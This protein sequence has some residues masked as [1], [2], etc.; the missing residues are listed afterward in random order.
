MMGI[1][2]WLKRFQREVI[3]AVVAGTVALGSTW[4]AL[5]LLEWLAIDTL[6][7]LRPSEAPDSRLLLV[8]VEESDIQ[9]LG[10]WPLSDAIL[11]EVLETLAAETPRVIGLDLYRDLPQEPG[12]DRLQTLMRELPNLVGIEKGLGGGLV[13]PPPILAERNLVGLADVPQDRDGTIRR[14]IV[15]APV[16]EKIKLG[17]STQV[18]LLYL[19]QLGITLEVRD[20]AQHQYQLGQAQFSPLTGRE[21]G[22]SG[23][24]FGGY[25][26][27]LNYRHPV[28]QFDQVSVSELLQGNVA[29]ELIRDRI[30]LIGSNAESINDFFLT[31]YSQ[32]I[33]QYRLDSPLPH[34]SAM[35]NYQM[36]GLEIHAHGVSQ[37][38]TSALDGR[39]L[40][41]FWHQMGE[42]VWIL[43]WTMVGTYGTWLGLVRQPLK[44]HSTW[45]YPLLLMISGTVI[46]GAIAYTSI[47]GG[48]LIPTVSP[49]IALILSTTLSRNAYQQQQLRA[50]NQQLQAYS[51]DLE[52]QVRQRTQELEAARQAADSANM[53]KSEFLANMSHEL[54]TPLNGILGYAQILQQAKDLNTQRRG[55]GVIYQCG[56]YLLEL[57]NDILDLSKIEARKLELN[58]KPIPLK[59]FLMQAAQMFKPAAEKKE[60]AFHSELDPQLPKLVIAD[61]KRLRQV[62]VNLISNA[63]KFTQKGSVNLLVE[64][65]DTPSSDPEKATDVRLRF[66]VTDTGIGM[67]EEELKT[68]FLP[69]EQ[70]KEAQKLAEG[71]GLGLAICCQLIRLMGSTLNVESQPGE[72]SC[73]QFELTLPTL[74]SKSTPILSRDYSKITAVSGVAPRLLLVDPSAD[75][76]S[77]LA[78]LLTPL[79]FSI[80]EAATAQETFEQLHKTPPNAIIL[81][82]E[83]EGSDG[84]DLIK[85]LRE[86]NVNYQLPIIAVSSYVFSDAKQRSLEAGATAFLTK[87]FHRNDV[88]L[89]LERHLQLRWAVQEES[90]PQAP[91]HIEQVEEACPPGFIPEPIVEELLHLARKGNLKDLKRRAEELQREHPHLSPF[92][93]HIMHLARQYQ[94]RA[95]CEFLMNYQVQ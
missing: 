74:S 21:G 17:F 20:S 38:L 71:T 2:R 3:V 50:F 31:P 43:A 32:A 10:G 18:S 79:G 76:R 57:I 29:P 83:L 85:T 6:L 44:E 62:L 42:W 88:L 46:I 54:R 33:Y 39:P 77:I 86:P 34:D 82:L 23:R 91:R 25:Q 4:G 26:V 84:V 63:I 94:E 35:P 7:V 11:A 27:F 40:I 28:H 78:A 93:D 13:A 19:E 12:H 9:V 24:D 81:K 59:P 5:E 8:T 67:T 1:S 41:R 15:S 68:V 16:D 90:A 22:Y 65:I 56:T 14:M 64:T 80:L 75:S 73:F 66:S 47:L 52:E 70:V 37:I 30:V 58:P 60:I 61:E 69:F 92:A 89:V 55:V 36:S 87:P 72:G 53:A 95:L 45:L 49:L 48:W 51:T